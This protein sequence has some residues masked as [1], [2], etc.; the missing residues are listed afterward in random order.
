MWIDYLPGATLF[1]FCYIKLEKAVEP[2]YELLSVK[3]GKKGYSLA[4]PACA[5]A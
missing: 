2:C 5:C 3:D 1:D 4:A